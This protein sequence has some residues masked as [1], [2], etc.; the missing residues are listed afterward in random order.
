[1]KRTRTDRSPSPEQRLLIN[2]TQQIVA[3]TSR[4]GRP[5]ILSSQTVPARLPALATGDEHHAAPLLPG[6]NLA[7]VGRVGAT[8]RPPAQPGSAPE[9]AG[10]QIYDLPDDITNYITHLLG[11]ETDRLA[12]HL[13]CKQHYRMPNTVR[14]IRLVERLL[15]AAGQVP[16]SLQNAVQRSPLSEALFS[17]EA[18]TLI[19]LNT[20]CQIDKTPGNHAQGVSWAALARNMLDAISAA[21]LA[22]ALLTY[23]QWIRLPGVVL[24]D[25]GDLPIEHDDAGLAKP[26]FLV[27][28]AL[29][30]RMRQP[31]LHRDPATLSLCWLD[32]LLHWSLRCSAADLVQLDANVDAGTAFKPSGHSTFPLTSAA[33]TIIQCVGESLPSTPQFLRTLLA[34]G[35]RN[36][37]VFSTGGSGNTQLDQASAACFQSLAMPHCFETFS[38]A[39]QG[40]DESAR[41]VLLTAVSSDILSLQ[42]HRRWSDH[43]FTQTYPHQAV[44]MLVCSL[45]MQLNR[46]AIAA[47]DQTGMDAIRLSMQALE[48]ELWVIRKI[49]SGSSVPGFPGL[50]DS[51]SEPDSADTDD[52]DTTTIGWDTAFDII[53]VH[54]TATMPSHPLAEL[55]KQSFEQ[56]QDFIPDQTWEFDHEQHHLLKSIHLTTL[57]L[58]DLTHY[59]A[60]LPGAFDI[61]PLKHQLRGIADLW[62][63]KGQR[64]LLL[65]WVNALR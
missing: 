38:Q 35:M 58:R 53:D 39:A 11:N 32:A 5:P 61:E 49:L 10:A 45:L 21:E 34:L 44:C 28:P 17:P 63:H 20:I 56:N 16:A 13:S 54:S 2:A 30:Q 40:L 33:K 23:T 22:G 29:V 1:M 25:R 9:Q 15:I 31:A 36:Y 12:W 18:R 43:P 26:R 19:K 57:T 52:T 65:D 24:R 62:P 42:E 55:D 27:T 37:L 14:E 60:L 51:L 59:I 50:I 46:D 47:G 6:C 7:L 48:S 64:N 3:A 41:A 4:H 8:V